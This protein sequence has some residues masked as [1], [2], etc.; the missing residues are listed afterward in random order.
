MALIPTGTAAIRAWIAAP[1]DAPELDADLNTA[2]TGATWAEP[3]TVVW[4]EQVSY[5]TSYRP[6]S[7][8]VLCPVTGVLCPTGVLAIGGVMGFAAWS[9]R[10]KRSQD[11]DE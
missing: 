6:F 10:K 2:L 7:A 11:L 5:Y 8:Q 4:T 9:R 3:H 1:T